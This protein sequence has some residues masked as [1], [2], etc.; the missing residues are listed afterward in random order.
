MVINRKPIPIGGNQY[1]T[2]EKWVEEWAQKEGYEI[3]KGTDQWEVTPEAGIPDYYLP[4]QTTF[5]EEKQSLKDKL[6][7]HQ[8]EKCLYLQTLGYD[9]AVALRDT[10]AII[11]LSIYL[12]LVNYNTQTW[13]NVLCLG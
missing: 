13:K 6:K 4:K 11:P 9:I 12:N 7:E 5:I 10:G 8:L 2:P 3:I 1:R